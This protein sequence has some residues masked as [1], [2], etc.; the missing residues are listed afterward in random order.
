[1]GQ[2]AAEC[3]GG[4]NQRVQFL[5]TADGELEVAWSDTLDLEVLCGIL[6]RVGHGQLP[7]RR[8]ESVLRPCQNGATYACKLQH[9][10]G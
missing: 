8:G 9:F 3:N 6:S 2:H 10:G 1:M 7:V 5:V 4:T